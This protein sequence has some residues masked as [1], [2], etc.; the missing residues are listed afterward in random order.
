VAVQRHS[1]RR[2]I[3][4]YRKHHRPIGSSTTPCALPKFD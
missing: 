1:S 4:K 3:P 2:P